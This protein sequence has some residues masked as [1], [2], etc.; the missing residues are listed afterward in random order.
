MQRELPLGVRAMQKAVKD[1]LDPLSLF[2]PGKVIG[3][4]PD[5]VT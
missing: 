4:D 3:A 5:L 1:A 2:N